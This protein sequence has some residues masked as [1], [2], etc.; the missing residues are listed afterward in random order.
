MFG[1]SIPFITVLIPVIG[2][3]FIIMADRRNIIGIKAISFWTTLF[4]FIFS[5]IPIFTSKR[6]LYGEYERIFSNSTLEYEIILDA[7]S[8]LFVPIICLICLLCLLWITKRKTQKKKSYY[9]SILLFEALSAGAFYVTNIFLLYILIEATIIP[10]Y[11]IMAQRKDYSNKAIFYFLLYTMISAILILIAFIIIYLNTNTCELKEIYKIGIKS[12]SVFWLLALGIGI[13]LP[14]WPFYSWLPIVHVKNQT[15]CS[16]LLA[17]IV[18]KF[19]VLILLRVM[20]PLFSD[21]IFSHIYIVFSFISISLIFALS[22]LIFQDDI[23]SVFAYFSIIHLNIAL[24]ILLDKSGLLYYI[25]SIMGHSILMPVLFFTSNIIDRLYGTRSIESL[26]T[27]AIQLP[28]VRRIV[29]LAFFALIA[30]PFSWGFVSEILTIQIIAKAS[31]LYAIF[32]AG[33][34]LISSL[35]VVYIYNSF[36]TY[37]KNNTTT[38]IIDGFYITD[39]YKK[40]A[41]YI[42][43]ILIFLVGI[44]PKIILD[45]FK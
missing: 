32:P 25:F 26:K 21:I 9:I 4:S 18:L 8:L 22:Q 41:F 16:I 5:V 13:K 39:I 38:D 2:S 11:I 23:K 20:M 42:P 30:L 35:F 12:K 24:F 33:I 1:L 14:I 3:F 17:S 7:L 27:S 28:V 43:V 34:I 37:K 19:S 10:L 36:L 31:Y 29:S 44:F 40:L 15:I 6:F 45:F